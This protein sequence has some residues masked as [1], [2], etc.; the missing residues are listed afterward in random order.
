MRT[1]TNP[2][3]TAGQKNSN[4][5]TCQRRLFRMNANRKERERLAWRYVWQEKTNIYTRTRE[6]LYN[7]V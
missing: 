1:F 5:K 6:N 3:G 7:V 4:L 2:S